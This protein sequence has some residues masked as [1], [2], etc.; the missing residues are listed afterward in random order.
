M[1]IEVHTDYCNGNHITGNYLCKDER[2]SKLRKG[3]CIMCDGNLDFDSEYGYAYCNEC[4]YKIGIKELRF[5]QSL[6]KQE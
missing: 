3:I 6:K 5:L 4:E 2:V 1:S